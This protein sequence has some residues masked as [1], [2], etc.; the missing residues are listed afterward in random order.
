M[1]EKL[2]LTPTEALI[3]IIS[4]AAL[5]WGFI[6]IVRLLGQRALAR[7]SSPDMATVVALGAVIGRAS[8]GYTPTLGA[9]LL[10]LVTLFA[11]QALAGQVR[12][13]SLY[14]TSLNNVPWLLMVGTTAIAE[15]L[16]RTHLA[17]GELLAQIRLAGVRHLSE[18]AC[19]ILEPTG[20]ISVLRRG[21]PM[22]RNLMA[23]VRGIEHI[24]DQFFDEPAQ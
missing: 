2:L 7:I 18:V 22:D 12:R 14:P 3:V 15:N 6:I 10:A 11:M 4:T 21:I 23:D 1:L 9:G 20:E 16:H 13:H 24:P 8:L 17:E 5:Y 19:V